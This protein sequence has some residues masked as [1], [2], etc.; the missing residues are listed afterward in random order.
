MDINN[1]SNLIK[2]H[3]NESKSAGS[4]EKSDAVSPKKDNDSI[5]DK[6]SI[7]RQNSMKSEEHFAKIELNKLNQTSFEKLKLMKAKLVEY[8]NA[9]ADS[10]DKA[11][12]TELGKLLDNPDVWGD[13]ANK[14]LD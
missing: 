2:N 7:D 13:I 3:I 14:I 4:S 5:S 9:K 6:V 12:K 1:I 11:A 8:E 10:P